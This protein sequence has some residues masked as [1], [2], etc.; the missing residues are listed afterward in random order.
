MQKPTLGLFV[1]E[2]EVFWCGPNFPDHYPEDEQPFTDFPVVVA[3]EGID[4]HDGNGW[5][6]AALEEY[7][8]VLEA[9]LYNVGNGHENYVVLAEFETVE[10]L[11]SAEKE[12]E[13]LDE[14][15]KEL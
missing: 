6:R 2:N 4:V 8:D 1:R 14:L 12:F 15:Y 9:Y 11:L 13:F 7:A 3:V 5:G 10:D